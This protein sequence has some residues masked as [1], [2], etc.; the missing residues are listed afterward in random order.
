VEVTASARA[1]EVI[2]EMAAL[3]AGTLTVTIGTGCCE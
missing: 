1:A 3:R 2:T